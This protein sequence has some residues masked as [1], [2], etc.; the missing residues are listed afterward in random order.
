MSGYAWG[1]YMDG[2]KA[3]GMFTEN[4][5]KGNISYLV[6]H[7]NFQIYVTKDTFLGAFRHL[8]CYF[9]HEE[10]WKYAI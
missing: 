1:S 9:Q 5:M 10:I 7:S 2:I 8:Y 4:E 6:F 3:Q